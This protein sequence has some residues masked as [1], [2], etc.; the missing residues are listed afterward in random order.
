M[1]L[2]RMSDSDNAAVIAARTP[3]RRSAAALASGSTSAH[4]ASASDTAAAAVNVGLTPNV[5]VAMPP[6]NGPAMTPTIAAAFEKLTAWPRLPTGARAATHATPAP[7]TAASP[8]PWTARAARS[9]QN[10]PANPRPSVA[11]AIATAP[12]ATT[13]RAPMRSARWPS[14]IDIATTAMLNA[15]RSH[16]DS[17]LVRP[18]SER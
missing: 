9:A 12:A 8:T 2:A 1:T 17:T 16:P 14:G 13:R 10:E 7:Q 6:M 11:T 5:L 3:M 15:A 4:P 18:S